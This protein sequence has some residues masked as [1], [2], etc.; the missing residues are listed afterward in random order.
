M[1]NNKLK[2]VRLILFDV[3]GVLTDGSIIYSDSGEE[4]KMFNVRDGLGIRLLMKADI[5]VGVVTGRR[6]EALRHRCNNL[7]ITLLYDGVRDKGA[8]LNEIVDKTGCRLEDIAFL[9]DDLPDLPIMR[10]VGFSIA[11]ADAHESVIEQADMVTRAKGGG[12]AV[13]EVCEK[14]L[15]SRGQWKQLTDQLFG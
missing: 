6:S 9:G 5:N 3:D 2:N 4:I 15:K 13:R 12:G 1:K 8:I 10:K 14:I 7:G 11:V